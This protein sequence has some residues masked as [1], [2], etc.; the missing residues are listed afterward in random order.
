MSM[1]YFILSLPLSR[2]R[3][4]SALQKI[5]AMNVPFEIVDGVE[6]N[7]LQPDAL[8]W[9]EHA[10][11]WMKLGEVGCYM[12]HMRILQRIV[13]YGLKFA[14]VL[15]DDFCLE[16]DPEYGLDEIER[17]L[18]NGFHYIHLQR[19]CGW[20]PKYRVH[21]TV[22]NYWRVSET[23]LGSIGYIIE[24]SLAEYILNHH[25]VCT[26]Q[27]DHLFAQLSAQGRFYQPI[28]PVVGI[29][30]GLKSDIQV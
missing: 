25:A 2:Q 3:R 4:L 26:M 6:A 20:N 18:P 21:A 28:K 27:I 30:V 23:P 7:R 5:Q 19:N 22:G 24:R 17:Y 11:T 8:T 9:D 29:E 1:Q 12:G 16:A 15:E 10:K 13:D 14:C